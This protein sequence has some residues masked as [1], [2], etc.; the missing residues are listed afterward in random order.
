MLFR[1]SICEEVSPEQIDL[2][3]WDTHVASR[4]TYTQSELAGIET[5]T[6]PAG[7]G[8][9]DPTCVPKFM[10]K[11]DIKAECLIFLTDGYVGDQDPSDYA[12][13]SMPVLWC[14]KGNRHF[15]TP[16]G[17]TVHVE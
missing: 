16:V 5:V 7:G 11:H 12:S 4:E 3:Y 2:L 13:L 9:T 8:G 15:E 17:K 14:V 1:S 10:A 6:K